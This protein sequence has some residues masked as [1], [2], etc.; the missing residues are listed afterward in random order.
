MVHDQINSNGNYPKID[1]GLLGWIR[2][3]PLVADLRSATHLMGDG[4]VRRL[5]SRVGA[6]GIPTAMVPGYD[7]FAAGFCLVAFVVALALVQQ[8]GRRLPFSRLAILACGGTG[9]L[10]LRGGAGVAQDVYLA[11]VGRN[12]P[13]ADALWD[14]WFCLG[15]PVRH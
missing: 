5:G 12:L 4:V 9:L 11:A 3:G 7:L 15:T 10:A 8:W 6:A 2:R 1:Q 14:V 13:D